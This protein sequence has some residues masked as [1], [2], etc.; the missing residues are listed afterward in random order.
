MGELDGR[1]FRSYEIIRELGH[2]GMAVV[3]LG[4]QITMD[5]LVAIKVIATLYST[6]DDFRARFDQEAHTIARLEHPHI[7]PV[8]DY[9]E[10]DF[11]AFLVMRYVDGGT[12]E[13]RLKAGPLRFDEAYGLLDRVASALDYAHSRGIVH[14]D[15]KP[16]N[17]L[18]D[19]EANPYLTDFGIAKI[20]Q[21]TTQL[22]RTGAAVGTPAYMAPEQWKGE[23]VGPFTD[24]YAL[25][26]VLYEMVTGDLPFKAD[27]TFGYMHKHIYEQPEPPNLVLSDLPPAAG[28]VILRALAKTPEE[29]Y[30]SMHTLLEAFGDALYDDHSAPTRPASSKDPAALNA[31]VVDPAAPITPRAFTPGSTV[32]RPRTPTPRPPVSVP[33][34]DDGTLALASDP[35]GRQ[36][37]RR[38]WLVIAAVA[39]LTVLGLAL[40]F[41]AGGA[42]LLGRG[43]TATFTATEPIMVAAAPTDLVSTECAATRAQSAAPVV[44]ETSPTA[45]PPPRTTESPTATPTSTSTPSPTLS[46]TPSHTPPPPDTPT[47]DVVETQ[48]A[49]LVATSQQVARDLTATSSALI[50]ALATGQAAQTGTAI[51]VSSFT[52]T[53]TPSPTV[54]LTPSVIPDGHVAADPYPAGDHV[55]PADHHAPA[56]CQF[57]APAQPDADLDRHGGDRV[58]PRPAAVAHRAGDAGHRQCQRSAPGQRPA[59]AGPHGDTHRAIAGG[60]PVHGAGRPH[61]P[62]WLSLVQGAAHR[63]QRPDWLDRGI[64]RGRVF[65]G[66]AQ[67]R[68]RRAGLP[69][70]DAPAPDA[71]RPGRGRYADRRAAAPA[72]RLRRE[73]AR[74]RAGPAGHAPDGPGWSALRGWIELVAVPPAGWAQRLGLRG[75]RGQ[76]FHHAGVAWSD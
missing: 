1:T 58:L 28:D 69:R 68:V 17:I 22:T 30:P 32:R 43:P 23:P 13:A 42:S 56:V 24:Q 19:S 41:A 50:V 57:H 37:G 36:S 67:Q 35:A 31:T 62:G 74:D 5:R 27:T 48:A 63:R 76:L 8:I 47:P 9:G 52:P 18:L 25:G 70:R 59:G 6:E 75:R 7:L 66:P 38:G 46:A 10:E 53:P 40:V 11:G 20:L 33:P 72:R 61:L 64:G 55:L 4:R 39:A 2:G 73:R 34:E 12:L 26:V 60:D 51:A 71:G 65:R 3:Y 21:N 44:P 15:L 54:T 45:T 14:R 49:A 16:A 29:R